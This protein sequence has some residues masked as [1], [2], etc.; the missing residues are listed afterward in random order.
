[1]P[2]SSGSIP[3]RLLP[4]KAGDQTVPKKNSVQPYW[5]KKRAVSKSSD[6]T[7]ATVVKI[8]INEARTSRPSVIASTRLRARN[9]GV[10]R[11]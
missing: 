10:I 7:I 3:S 11:T 5:P 1:M 9:S 8:A 2:Q 4:W 6:R